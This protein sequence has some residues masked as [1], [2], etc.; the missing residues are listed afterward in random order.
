MRRSLRWGVSRLA[1]AIVPSSRTFRFRCTPARWCCSRAHRVP[2]S[3]RLPR[4]SR[5]WSRLMRAPF[6]FTPARTT[7]PSQMLPLLPRCIQFPALSGCRSSSQKRS[8]SSRRSTTK[9]AYAPRNLSLS[10]D[11]VDR[12]VFKAID[13]VGL[14][15]KL[16]DASPFELSGGQARRVALASVLSLD[17]SVY[18]LDEPSAALDARGRAFAHRFVTDLAAEGRSVLVITH[19]VDEWRP[20]ATRELMLSNGSLHAARAPEGPSDASLQPFAGDSAMGHASRGPQAFGTVFGEYVPGT[21]VA[22]LDARVKIVLLLLAT[23]GVF[24]AGV[25][26]MLVVWLLILCGCLA[27]SRMRLGR[28]LRGNG[29]LPSSSRSRSLRTWCRAMAGERWSWLARLVSARREACGD[30]WL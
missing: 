4:L 6:A 14:D 7:P 8:F 12:R 15:R 26:A 24:S 21:P 2:A 17:A 22:R 5:D 20:F 23:A 16:A 11:E 10:E 28:V 9:V 18:V 27:S 19:D 29:P 3:R 25:P 30:S 1:M 13:A